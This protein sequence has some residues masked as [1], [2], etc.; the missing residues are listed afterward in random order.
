MERGPL[1]KAAPSVEGH[2]EVNATY[3]AS[4]RDQCKN[5][6]P[7]LES[8]R[9][10]KQRWLWISELLSDR[11]LTASA[12]VVAT[13]LAQFLNEKLGKA[14]PSHDRLAA[15]CGMAKSTM[16][17]AIA[18]LVAAGYLLVQGRGGRKIENGRAVG[19]TNEYRPALPA[20]E[21]AP[22]DRGNVASSDPGGCSPAD[23]KPSMEPSKED[24]PVVEEAPP[25]IPTDLNLFLADHQEKKIARIE[26]S[27]DL[28]I[29]P[30]GM[31]TEHAISI[32]LARQ[33]GAPVSSGR[34]LLVS[35]GRDIRY[36]LVIRSQARRLRAGELVKLAHSQ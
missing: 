5:T 11:E 15:A 29:A 17:R 24:S 34:Q 26:R 22:Q 7:H 4:S 23:N 31:T 35:L 12:K 1:V 33:I 2:F 6:T 3:M 36:D 25:L 28:I 10:S 16:R 27:D 9:L 14:W 19:I 8:F 18:E 21:I 13:G 20:Q 30:P 32:F